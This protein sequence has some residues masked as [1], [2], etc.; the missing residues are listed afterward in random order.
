MKIHPFTARVT[1]LA[2]FLSLALGLAGCQSI[3]APLGAYGADFDQTLNIRVRDALAADNVYKFPNV[4]IIS[5]DGAVQLSGFVDIPEQSQRAEQLARRV[6]GVTQVI[7]NIS[8]MDRQ[9]QQMEH[10]QRQQDYQQ[11]PVPRQ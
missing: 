7:N 2:I 8:V 1:S 11:Q 5:R 3:M 10:E 4:E 6:S 9:Q